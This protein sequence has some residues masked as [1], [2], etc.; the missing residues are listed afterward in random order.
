[1]LHVDSLCL[2][3]I[4]VLVYKLYW[5]ASHWTIVARLALLIR[6]LPTGL[7]QGVV[8]HLQ[9][10]GAHRNREGG[11]S[12]EGRKEGRKEGRESEREREKER[13]KAIKKERVIERD[14]RRE[15][16]GREEKGR[17]GK[18]RE[19]QRRRWARGA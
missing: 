5:R 10:R 2:R 4:R 8:L 1:M 16:K 3:F 15:E 12:E 13:K 19:G 9:L 17:T 6:L 14:E 7:E 18:G 11:E